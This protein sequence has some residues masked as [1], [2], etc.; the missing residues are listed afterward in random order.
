MTTYGKRI[1]MVIGFIII[2]GCF[3]VVSAAEIKIAVVDI[4]KAM[5]E[6]N[7]GKEAKKAL[8]K[9]MEK[10]QRQ[11]Q[12][13]QQDLQTM[14]TSLKKQAPM[15]TAEAQEKKGKE[16]QTKVRDYQRWLDDNQKEIQQKGAGV[17]REISIA[18]LKVIKKIGEEE[19]FTFILE[20]N[21]NIVLFASKTIEITDRVIKAFDAQKK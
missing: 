20:K 12:E 6:C 3:G 1:G 11:F 5:N 8:Q 19:G 2:V 17:E 9:E 10:I 13:K 18:L 7:E 15:L 21:E 14:E 16:F 4:Q